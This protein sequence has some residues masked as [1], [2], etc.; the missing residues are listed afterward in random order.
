MSD[1]AAYADLTALVRDLRN[2]R[3][4]VKG[5]SEKL[6]DKTGKRVEI[7][8]RQYAPKDTGKLSQSIR[9][10]KEPGRRTIGAVGVEYDVY[11]EFGTGLRGEFSGQMITVKKGTQTYQSRGVRPQPF[12]RPA[13]RD[14]LDTMLGDYLSLG[15]NLIT[16]GKA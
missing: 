8:M 14:A 2:A 16:K 10:I 6:L 9:M 3:R 4:N 11:Q 13:A 5:E 1:P 15:V 12:A 7:L